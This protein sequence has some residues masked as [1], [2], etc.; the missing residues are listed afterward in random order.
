VPGPADVA[1]RADRAQLLVARDPRGHIVGSVALV[2]DGAFGEVAEAPPR[3][4]PERARG[5]PS[6]FD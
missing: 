3:A 4:S 2:L 1:G 6:T 5:G